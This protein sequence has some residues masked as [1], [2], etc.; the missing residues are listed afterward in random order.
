MT[1][2][3]NEYFLTILGFL[4][5]QGYDGRTSTLTTKAVA[6]IVLVFSSLMYQFYGTFI[7]GSLLTPPPKNLKTI[8]QLIDSNFQVTMENLFYNWDFFNRTKDPAAIELF[9][10]KIL[11]SVA[12]PT[13]VSHGIVLIRKGGYAVQCDIGYTY[14]ILK[15]TF[16]D[17]EICDLQDIPISPLRPLHLPLQKGS[18]LKQYFRVTLR[19]L[20][21]SGS[22]GYYYREYFSSK[23]P[24]PKSDLET[25]QI[26]VYQVISIFYFL[27]LGFLLSVVILIIERIYYRY[28]IAPTVWEYTN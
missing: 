8:R 5:Q 25:T 12:K 14:P 4:C 26:D 22:G 11:K 27:A 6:L 28:R 23:P 10:K 17:D 19:K 20:I 1:V 3:A 21:E 16:T 2:S 7:I 24:C 15:S 13:N 9:N 18:P